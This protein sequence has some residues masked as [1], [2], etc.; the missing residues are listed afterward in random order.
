MAFITSCPKCKKQVLVPDGTCPESSCSVRAAWRIFHGRDPRVGPPA[1]IVIH[2]GTSPLGASSVVAAV[3]A[4]APAASEGRVFSAHRV[5]PKF[6]DTEP[7]LFEG[8]A[9]GPAA[10]AVAEP[11]GHEDIEHLAK[12]VLFASTWKSSRRPIARPTAGRW[13]G[14]PLAARGRSR[15]PRR[16]GRGPRAWGGGG[17]NQGRRGTRA[18]QRHR[19]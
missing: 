10:A 2:P 19:A 11:A 6:D 3:A 5:K 15:S 14:E 17:Q 7:L 9:G 13:L 8:D 1:L 12:P 16:V 18:R 4:A